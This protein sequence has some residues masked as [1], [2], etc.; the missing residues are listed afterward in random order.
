MPITIP[1]SLPRCSGG[2]L[3]VT[4]DM[5]AVQI[6]PLAKPWTKRARIRTAAFGLQAKITVATVIST[7]DHSEMRRAPIRGTRTMHASDTN[8]TEAG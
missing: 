2:A 3:S 6:D 8:G 5:E 1:D 7:A 4:H